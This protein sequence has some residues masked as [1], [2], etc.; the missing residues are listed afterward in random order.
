LRRI[1]LQIALLLAPVSLL[2]AAVP[3]LD[4]IYPAG[5]QIGT[6]FEVSLIGNFDPWPIQIWCG[7]PA[8]EFE[9]GKTKGSLKVKITA[10]A[11]VGPTLIRV[12]NSEG[13]SAPKTFMVG[14]FPEILEG[15]DNDA[16]TTPQPLSQ[17][18][19]VVNGKLE[20]RDDIDF[21][22]LP[23]KKGQTLTATIDGYG[24]GSAIDPFLHLYGPDGQE[25][26]LAS[27]SRN[28][29]PILTHAIAENGDY[30]IQVVAIDHK[31]S[32]N[33]SFAGGAAMIYRLNLRTDT[34][35]LATFPTAATVT[36]S[37][38]RL[39]LPG[40][41]ASNLRLDGK[42]DSFQIPAEKGQ[43]IN[44]RIEAHQH[45]SP[46]DGVL[47]IIRPDE[48][49]YRTVD[50]FNKKPDP[51]I[52]L[53]APLAGDYEAQIWDRF[54]RGG[55]EFRYH[56][57]LEEPEPDFSAT[58]TAS[59]FTL[60][61]G[62][63]LEV[64]IKLVRANG[65]QEPLEVQIENLPNGVHFKQPEVPEKS[66][67]V[68][69]KLEAKPDAIPTSVPLKI[70]LHPSTATKSQAA[71]YSFQTSGSRGA[72]LIDETEII[73]LTLIEPAKSVINSE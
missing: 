50:D 34:P 7:N 73:W 26:A 22:R 62:K 53:T 43:K 71:T 68:K 46:L 17:I 19:L 52:L 2:L 48:K 47:S 10:E 51:E 20:K 33:V 41:Y 55:P 30:T 72:Y 70:R 45:G 31:A 27:D 38:N 59:A 5:G 36:K 16:L 18:P 23:L 15:A 63:S 66:G 64:P 57:V 65:H 13:A 42:P 4:G 56:L 28:L 67:D 58:V 60:E 32:S 39:P 21:F 37:G 49:L 61:V 24:L 54:Q 8:I 35:D 6:T 25:I 1:A 11:E 3:Q 40:R 12:F 14:A 69:L 9:P 29:D 44:I